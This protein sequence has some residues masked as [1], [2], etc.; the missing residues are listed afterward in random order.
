M[1]LSLQLEA[2]DADIADDVYEAYTDL[3]SYPEDEDETLCFK[4]YS[5]VGTVV[6]F[7]LLSNLFF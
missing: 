4:S 7:P 1:I 5:M 6:G 3:L 2:E